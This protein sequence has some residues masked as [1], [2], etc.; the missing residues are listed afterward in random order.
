MKNYCIKFA[1]F[2]PRTKNIFG[3]E[4]IFIPAAKIMCYCLLAGCLFLKVSTVLGRTNEG[5]SLFYT[6]IFHSQMTKN[7]KN[8]SGAKYSNS[9]VTSNGTKSVPYSKFLIE[10][11]AKNTAYAFLLSHG[12]YNQFVNYCSSYHSSNPHNDCVDYLLSNA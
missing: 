8:Y 6:L 11:N 5:N 2:R 3:N 9:K 1:A 10:M 7:V 12:L 4:V